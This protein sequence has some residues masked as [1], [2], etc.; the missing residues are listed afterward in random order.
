MSPTQEDRIA[1]RSYQ[2]WEREGKPE[3]KHLQHWFQ[4]I[5]ELEAKSTPA[6]S[7]SRARRPAAARK[8]R[9]A[10]GSRSAVRKA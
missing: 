2:I 1:E 9:I 5:A 3:G 8:E 7:P 10:Q 6:K 4:A